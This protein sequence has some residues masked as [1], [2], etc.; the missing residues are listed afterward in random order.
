MR[1]WIM[2]SF[3]QR[4]IEGSRWEEKHAGRALVTNPIHG[5]QLLPQPDRVIPAEPLRRPVRLFSTT[6]SYKKG[7]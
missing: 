4:A 1:G 6:L 5:I 2:R 3:G 7:E